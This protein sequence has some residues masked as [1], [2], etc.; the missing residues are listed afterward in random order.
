MMS[1]VNRVVF[2]DGACGFCNRSV[3][4]VLKHDKSRSIC[5]APLQS[6]YC[7][8]RFQENGWP[9]PDLSTFYFL[10]D[11][12]LYEKSTAALKVT[13]YFAFPQSLMRIGWI[14]PRFLRDWCYDQ[15]AKRRQRISKGF[16]VVPSPEDRE[17]F[18][19]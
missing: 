4:Y 13:K 8:E 9:K 6:A 11:G 16:C 18:I 1:K 14:A 7:E 17:R 10:D 15:I 12:Q 2:Y 3:N 5:F 19:D